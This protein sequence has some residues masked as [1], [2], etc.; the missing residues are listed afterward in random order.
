METSQSPYDPPISSYAQISCKNGAQRKGAI[1]IMKNN[2][3]SATKKTPI[4]NFSVKSN[5][6]TKC[7]YYSKGILSGQLIEF[8]RFGRKS[9]YG[10]FWRRRIRIHSLNQRGSLF[11][12]SGP[13]FKS[14]TN[15]TS[16][17]HPLQ[18]S[19]VVRPDLWKDRTFFFCTTMLRATRL[20][21]SSNFWLKKG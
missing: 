8:V 21:K 7:P 2:S 20:Q 14:V 15:P 10:G 4:T 12:A 9:G 16:P 5:E 3:N 18:K 6:L 19:S 17:T 13:N 1:Q 11:S